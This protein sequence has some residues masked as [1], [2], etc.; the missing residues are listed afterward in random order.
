MFDALAL[1]LVLAQPAAA[2]EPPKEYTY[3]VVAYAPEGVAEVERLIAEFNRNGAARLVPSTKDRSSDQT[4]VRRPDAY[5][6]DVA[7]CLQQRTMTA[8]D[9]KTHIRL[10]VTRGF[11]DSRLTCLGPSYPGHASLRNVH[12][13]DPYLRNR[14][15]AEV[16]RCLS[17]TASGS[18]S[19]R[20]VP[21]PIPPMR[22]LKAGRRWSTIEVD[23]AQHSASDV[24]TL[25]V[26]NVER[27]VA[28]RSGICVVAG[29]VTYVE[30]GTKLPVLTPVR[31]TLPCAASGSID[32]PR[33][34]PMQSIRKDMIARLFVGPDGVFH[35]IAPNAACN[36]ERQA[37]G[38]SP[39]EALVRGCLPAAGQP[40]SSAP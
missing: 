19:F 38:E 31:I 32:V 4:C 15:R 22:D 10:L 37:R 25:L 21:E 39:R 27:P 34:L 30:R 12:S 36:Y 3:S 20:P 26:E 29:R 28:A 5:W 9:N 18:A 2:A 24:V 14:A 1:S 17:Y 13:P 7:Y 40:V 6:G 16:A 11:T 8:T 23:E 35:D 33:S